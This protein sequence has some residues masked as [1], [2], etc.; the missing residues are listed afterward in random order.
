MIGV[1]RAPRP[2]TL[3]IACSALLHAAVLVPLVLLRT[4]TPALLPPLYK[5]DLLAAPPGPRA[6]G[7]VTEAP[8]PPTPTKAPPKAAARPAPVKA[9][10][11][12]KA[13]KATKVAKAPVQATPNVTKQAPAKAA[14]L[15]KAAGGD[16]GGKGTDVATVRTEGIEFPFRGYLEN[17]TRQIALNFAPRGNVGALRCEVF[18]MI[19]RDGS[20]SGFK[21]LTRSGSQA[22]DLEAQGAVEA[23]SSRF[24]RLPDGYADDVLPVTFYFDPSRLR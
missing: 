8:P 15:P 7:I 19:R 17:I 16:V 22:F 24:G 21:F 10:P 13:T 12:A 23:A 14:E 6:A 1:R 3:P 11:K 9:P 20:V 18:F 2:L 5:V 4:S